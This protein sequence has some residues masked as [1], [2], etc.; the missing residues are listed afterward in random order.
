MFIKKCHLLCSHFK[1]TIKISIILIIK[2]GSREVK[3][4][5]TQIIW[6]QRP[7]FKIPALHCLSTIFLEKNGIASSHI[8]ITSFKYYQFI[9]NLI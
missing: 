5:W 7:W 3:N 8:F 1:V 4:A 9:I 6:L 2:I